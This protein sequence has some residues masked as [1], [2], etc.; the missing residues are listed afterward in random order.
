MLCHPVLK[1]FSS[2]ES[3]HE[4]SDHSCDWCRRTTE[5]SPARNPSLCRSATT[6]SHESPVCH[7][8]HTV[9]NSNLGCRHQTF[10]LQFN[11]FLAEDP[12]VAVFSVEQEAPISGVWRDE[13]RRGC[14]GLDKTYE[15]AQIF[16]G[17][18]SR[19]H[20]TMSVGRH[21]TLGVSNK[22][23]RFW[24]AK[25]GVILLDWVELYDSYFR[26]MKKTKTKNRKKSGRSAERVYVQDEDTMR[27][28]DKERA[29]RA[30][31]GSMT[32][33]STT[34]ELSTR[35]NNGLR[36]VRDAIRSRVGEG[37]SN[38]SG[39]ERIALARVPFIR[40]KSNYQRLR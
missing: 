30:T 27:N 22:A 19:C 38:G 9:I 14:Y 8:P 5:L 23:T 18:L 1:M 35:F 40:T 10:Q 25:D 3:N 4:F 32:A 6:T 33:V 16:S 7:L 37:N 34:H 31:S 26:Q 13:D 24:S 28:H 15:W 39:E 36:V 12:S 2:N 29:F 21:W 11:R 20:V 17:S